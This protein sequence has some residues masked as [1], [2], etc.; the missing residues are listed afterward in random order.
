MT[1]EKNKNR[2]D[3]FQEGP[4]ARGTGGIPFQPDASATPLEPEPVDV[5][6][7]PAP[8]PAAPAESRGFGLTIGNKL[9]VAFLAVSLV[10][11]LAIGFISYRN[12]AD[13]LREQIFNHLDTVRAI[14]KNQIIQFI[15]ERIGDTKVLS[16]SADVREAVEQ[17]AV[18]H[19]AGGGAT[20]PYDTLSRRYKKL[21]DDIYPF[22]KTSADAY[23]YHDI[24]LI[25]AEHGHVMFTMAKE[26]DLGTNLRTGLYRNS[27]LARLWSKAVKE[28]RGV[29]ED[30]EHY[31]ASDEPAAFL[32]RPVFDENGKLSAVV[33]IQLG[34]KHLNTIMQERTGLGETG[35]TYLVGSD[36]LMRSD[37]RFETASTILKKKIDTE[38]T[39]NA[40]QGAQ[41]VKV[42]KDYRGESVL[43]S[44]SPTGLRKFQGVDFEWGIIAEIDEAEAFKPIGVIRNWILLITL[45]TVVL[46][47]VVSILITRSVINPLKNIAGRIGEIA[48]LAGDLTV[49][50]EARSADE[51]GDI[52]RAHNSM[53]ATLARLIARIRKSGVQVVSASA[54]ILS[55]SQQNAAAASQ[56]STQITEVTTA[57]NE[58]AATAKQ[59]SQTADDVA[60]IAEGAVKSAEYGAK[61]ISDTTSAVTRM[62]V[63]VKETARM[64][65]ELG[66][67]SKKITGIL[68]LLDDI[69]EQTNLLA[70]NAAIEA[71]RAGEAGRGFTVVAD[72]IRKL[73]DGS[74]KATK[75]ISALIEEIQTD[76]RDTVT[77]MEENT[78]LA[79]EGSLLASKSGDAVK[80]IISSIE[81]SFQSIKQITL[82]TQQQTSGAAQVSQTM[83]GINAAVKQTVAGVEQSMRSARGLASMSEQL[84]SGVAQ[85]KITE[86]GNHD[87]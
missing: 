18:Y 51:I 84:K 55:A 23:D 78:R 1:E 73:A 30:F 46:V 32:G 39:R 74:R 58:L 35:E 86:R 11:V 85:F 2:E 22:F 79:E 26:A 49:R 38:A 28:R 34:T 10:P 56:Q 9:M 13:S 19:E 42:L 37:S 59:I 7:S 33:A 83:A 76:T 65:E 12:S 24:L 64:M 3:R 82:S 40:L 63:S 45:V 71:S 81:G 5:S 6:M 67:K 14:K 48:S 29:M 44:Y 41:G 16:E 43:S 53:T 52:A 8:G 50:V 54:Q 68:D 31:G 20:G 61:S 72:E 80:D 69:T 60:K 4:A 17:L 77:G 87:A 75:D 66:R 21:Y 36:S 62:K 57:V 25:C 15:A 70:L 27:G 47:V